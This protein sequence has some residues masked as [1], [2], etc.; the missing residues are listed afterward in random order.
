MAMD[1]AHMAKI[2]A[3]RGKGKNAVSVSEESGEAADFEASEDE[4]KEKVKG[5]KGFGKM[6]KAKK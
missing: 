5:P 6:A 1:A 2:R 4:V 3:M